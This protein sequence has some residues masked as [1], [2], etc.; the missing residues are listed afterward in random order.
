[1]AATALA[2]GGSSSGS[3]PPASEDEVEAPKPAP[4]AKQARGGVAAK[5]GELTMP[6]PKLLEPLGDPPASEDAPKVVL[7]PP[8]PFGFGKVPERDAAGHWSVSGLRNDRAVQ[9]ERGRKGTEITVKAWVNEIYVRPVCPDGEVCPPAKQP[10]LWVADHLDIKGKKRSMMVVNYAFMIPEW[11]EETWRGVEAV[12]LKVGEQYVMKGEFKRFSD[13]G[14]ASEDGLFEFIA[15]QRTDETG[16]TRWVHP[17]GAA[18]HP[19]AIA[20]EEEQKAALMRR[21]AKETKKKR[22]R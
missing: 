18:W 8:P 11:E 3:P 17:R 7:P 14:F 1:M 16:A 9:L 15:V 12:E 20:I 10:H 13:T 5:L 22:R 2:C 21:I 4:E 19:V 6:A